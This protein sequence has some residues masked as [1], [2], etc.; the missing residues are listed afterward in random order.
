MRVRHTKLL[1]LLF[2]LTTILLHAGEIPTD[3]LL[4]HFYNRAANL[5]E[6]G[7]YDEAQ[8]SF[9]SAFATRN[10][11]HSFM[12]P[13]LLNE[14]ATLLIYVGKTEEAFA[15]KKNVLPYLPQIDDL[16]KHISVYNDLGLLYRQHQMNDSTLYY[17]NKALDSALQYGDESWIAHICNNVSILYF[18]IR[19]LDEAEKYTDMATE[20]AARTEDPF[21][22]FTTWQIRATI[23]AELNKLDDAEKS[24][25]KA[26]N[27]ACHGEGNEDLWKIRNSIA[28]IGFIQ[29]RAATETNRKNYARALKDFHWLRNRKTGTEPK[30]LFTQMARCYD[31]LGNPKL[32]YTY[33]DSARMWT[34]TLAQH[35]LTQQMAEFNVKYH[36]QEKELE[37][38]HLQQEQLE[39]QAFLLKASIAVALLSGLA[40]ITLLTL[41][42]KKRIAEKKIELLKQENELNSAR[43]YIEGLEEE[44]KYFAKELHDGIANDLLGLQMKIETSASKGNEQELPHSS[45]N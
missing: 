30:T 29:S 12:Y 25:R 5:M 43:R 44:C 13:I 31:A 10:V 2:S 21:V 39:H 7:H 9:D 41:R 35:N 37:I 40:L 36:T 4:A 32:A 16:E 23:K 1:S 17:Y 34:D 22:A 6:E 33:M 3:T 19:Q 14:Q 15:M 18:N 26:W 38:A 8:R 11:K 20:H 45:A 24:N 27:I 42:H 28:A